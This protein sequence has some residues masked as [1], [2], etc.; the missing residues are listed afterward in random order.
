[1]TDQPEQIYE[2]VLVVRAQSGDDLAF[3]ELVQRYSPRLRYF[4]GKLLLPGQ[5]Q[6]A[7]GQA[8]VEDVVQDVWLDVLRHLS[9]LSDPQALVAWLY[10]IARD[11]AFRKLRHSRRVEQLTDEGSI[12]DEMATDEDEFSTDDARRIHAALDDLPPLQREVLVLRF[13]EDMSY[14]QIARVVGCELGTV[15]SRIYYAKQSLRRL[16]TTA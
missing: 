6:T 10:R 11:H 8:G 12:I 14:E 16:L 15:R 13:L 9:R 5:S 4:V 7:A 1:M 2:R 3:A